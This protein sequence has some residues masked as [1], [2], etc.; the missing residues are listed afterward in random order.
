[1]RRLRIN[2]ETARHG[3]SR[4]F[5]GVRRAG[6][7]ERAP[8]AHLAAE[9]A[10]GQIR[11]PGELAGAAGEDDM[12]PPVGAERRGRQPVADHFQYFFDARLDDVDQR[13]AGYQLRLLALV[14]AQ[15]RHRDHVTL[16]RPPVQHSAIKRFDSLGVRHAGVESA[17]DI[18]GD[19]MA[20]EG[21]TLDVN[22]PPTQEGRHGGGSGAHIDHG[23]AKIG[24][25]VGQNGEAG[26]IGARHHGFDLKMAALDREHQVPRRGD[27]RRGDVHVDAEPGTQHAARVADAFD[28]IDRV[29]DRERVQYG[30]A[31]AQRMPAAGREDA[32]DIA[33]RYGGTDDFDLGGEQLAG[34]PSGRERQHHRFDFDARH[35]LGAIDG[36]ANGFLDLAEI[37]DAAGF[38]A[39]RDG[40]AEA[41]D[42]NAMAAAG[43][44]LLRR[45]RPQ[46]RDHAHD[47]ARTDIK[48]SDESAAPRR[49]RFHF[50]G[51]AIAQRVHASPPFFFLVLA[52]LR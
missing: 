35:A 12:A 24:L 47:L 43:Q 51:Q 38:H 44:N 5:G 17:R 19:V 1:M 41:D 23:R 7:A 16:V 22:Q 28:T 48:R 20:A 13:G 34:W 42:F 6:N 9:N 36:L 18:H 25:V 4:A 31:V 21:E 8:D 27:I 50:R 10:R 14:V 49:N 26:H 40:V 29:T 32:S 39:A 37:D 30:A 3:K 11:Q 52:L 45:A 46:P 33:V 15:R 2:E